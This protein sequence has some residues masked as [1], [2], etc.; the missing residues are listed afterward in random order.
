MIDE[1]DRNVAKLKYAEALNDVKNSIAESQSKKD[2]D[3][4][5]EEMKEAHIDCTKKFL[6]KILEDDQDAQK[7]KILGRFAD[8][9][10]TFEDAIL[11]DL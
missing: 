4:D 8:I 10:A 9:W 7:L 5:D 11:E 3:D 6:S 2:V 1:E